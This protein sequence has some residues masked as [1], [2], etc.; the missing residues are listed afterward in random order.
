MNTNPMMTMFLGF[1][2]MGSSA[3]FADEL[4][5]GVVNSQNPND[6]SLTPTQSL[7][8]ITV[9]EGFEV[10]LFAGE[11]DIRRPIAFDFDDRG[12]LWVVENYSHPHFDPD[13]KTDRIVIL[14]DTNHDGQ[15]DQRKVFWDQGRY[16]TAIAVGYGGV[17]IGNTPE[18]SFIPDR[19]FDDIP[20]GEPTV[21]LDG[22]AVS[23][24]NV[25][26][27]FHWGPDGWLYGAI[28]LN[29]TSLIGKPGTPEANRVKISRGMWR[30]HPVTHQFERIADGMVNPWGAD[31][32]AV[33]DLFTV[34]TVIAH[35]WHIVPGMYCQRRA[36][37][38]DYPYVYRRVQSHADHLHWGGGT[39][40][41]SRQTTATH[42]VAGG[43]HAHC[44]AMVY[45]GD[46]W[47]EQYRG[48][49]FTLNLHGARINQEVLTP[50]DSTYVAKHDQDLFMANDEWFRGLSLKYGPDGG[51]YITDWHDF[52]ECH[53][54]D[55]SHRTSGR[56]YKM[57]WGIPSAVSM[58]LQKLSQQELVNLLSHKN[59]WFVRHARRI[60]HERMALGVDQSQAELLINSRLKG[61]RLTETQ[62]L[63]FLWALYGMDAFSTDDLVQWTHHR[64]EHVRRWAIKL[65]FDQGEPQKFGELV[66]EGVV[67]PGIQ[68]RMVEMAYGDPS[69]KVLLAI[70]SSMRQV[71]PANR[72]MLAEALSKQR[73][74]LDDETLTLM[75]WYA[76]EPLIKEDRQRFIRLALE[77]PSQVLQQF[78]MRRASEGDEL[79]FEDVIA[80]IHSY[81]GKRLAMLEGVLQALSGETHSEPNS[82]NS[83]YREMS[84]TEDSEI[85][86]RLVRLA[87]IFGDESALVALRNLV[88]DEFATLEERQNAMQALA[89]IPG[90]LTT[91]LLHVTILAAN[92]LRGE[93]IRQLVTMAD[94][95]TPALLLEVFDKLD[96][97]QQTDAVAVMV[98]QRSSS[99]QLLQAIQSGK[100]GQES[101]NA[102][103]I[104]QLRAFGD[105]EIES[106]LT[107][108]WPSDSTQL[109]KAEE[110]SRLR[111]LMTRE[112]LESGD[113]SQ[114][115]LLFYKTCFK[116]HQL[117]GEGGRV[118]PDLTGSGRKQVDYLLSNLL[119][120]SAEIDA[121]YKLTTVISN[122][123][124]LYS[125]FVIHQDD[126][127][128][129]LRTQNA[130]VQ[131][132]MKDVDEIIPTKKSMMPEGMLRELSDDQIRDLFLYLTGSRQVPLPAAN[133]R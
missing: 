76:I 25:L 111:V 41:S 74:L 26:N 117:Y 133:D 84:K 125:G 71:Q 23:S 65:I 54:N 60:L 81:E 19:D 63:R 93:A 49:L 95:E 107:D 10:T 86:S 72:W 42:S 112:H 100:V 9:P 11:P 27:N 4:P 50:H 36:N 13:N 118:G 85:K 129:R 69:P 29:P 53:D 62:I 61:G 52:G 58:N 46:N 97:D 67:R 34:N 113:A 24:N 59:E 101:V 1:L 79:G 68:S 116:C 122:A 40:Q 110:I 115:R 131:L 82:W 75:T 43:G 126:R 92:Q 127:V 103:A 90:G 89:E 106:L 51:V 114:G 132:Q 8:K 38:G 28:G 2:L 45:L 39:W 64:S 119:D 55:G 66:L 32:N 56:I 5:E 30:M 16:V 6:V 70:A 121:D 33:G 104:E 109:Q 98:T 94:K 17:W 20:D 96:R 105:S 108:L 48:K 102:F 78:I 21:I 15:F 31:F 123:G 77:S 80:A 91:E 47:P 130:D 87:G 7:K 12:R 128:V 57:T 37:E 35:L 83:F 73:A 44:G 99:L 3:I 120:P 124:R 22:F 18:L 14:E 88:E